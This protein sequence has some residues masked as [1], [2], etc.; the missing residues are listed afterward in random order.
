MVK[1]HVPY[2]LATIGYLNI[3]E[4]LKVLVVNV[5]CDHVFE[6]LQVNVTIFQMH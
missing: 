1:N 4:I 5:N 6:L 3:H 2:C